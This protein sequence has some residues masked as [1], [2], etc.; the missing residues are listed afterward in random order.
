M[1][2]REKGKK[3]T[4]PFAILL[5]RLPDGNQKLDSVKCGIICSR[6]FDHRAVRRNR[7]RRLLWESFRLMKQRVTPC[8]MIFIPRREILNAR[9]QDV[10]VQM[11]MMFS[12][13][14]ILVHSQK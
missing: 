6:R 5:Y 1:L 2:V 11:E 14:R 10:A 12:K 7:A 4:S 8:Q 13:A 9:M 3:L